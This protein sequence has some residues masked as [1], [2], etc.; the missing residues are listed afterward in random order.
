MG[1][2]ITCFCVLGNDVVKMGKLT[3]QRGEN[4]QNNILS[5]GEEIESNIQMEGLDLGK[6]TDNSSLIAGG[7]GE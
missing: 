5:K 6:S 4:C 7:K 1:K 2:A 3:C